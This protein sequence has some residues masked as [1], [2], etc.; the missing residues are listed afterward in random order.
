MTSVR[1]LLVDRCA[2]FL[3]GLDAWLSGEPDIEVLGFARTGPEAIDLARR[4]RPDVVLIDVSLASP[5][6]FGTVRAL[7]AHDAA[8]RIVLMTFHDSESVR[9]EAWAAGADATL[10]RDRITADLLDV[11]RRARGPGAAR[12]PDRSKPPEDRA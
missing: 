11:V 8:P 7:K 4:L 5:G 12:R 2:D 1:V 6:G 9:E 3:D 10:A